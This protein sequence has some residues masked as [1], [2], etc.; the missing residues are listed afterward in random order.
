MGLGITVYKILYTCTCIQDK[1]IICKQPTKICL[2]D[3][4]TK[5]LGMKYSMLAVRVRGSVLEEEGDC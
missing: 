2:Q 1:K 5:N 4:I 3:K